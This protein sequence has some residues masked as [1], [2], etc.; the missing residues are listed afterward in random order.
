M[1]LDIAS[2]SQT[3]LPHLLKDAGHAEILAALASLQG[4]MNS[5]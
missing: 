5:M 4:G 1:V 3:A 2:S